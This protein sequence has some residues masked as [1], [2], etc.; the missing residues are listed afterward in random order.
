VEVAYIQ[1]TQNVL[2]GTVFIPITVLV[3][4]FLDVNHISYCIIKVNLIAVDELL[5]D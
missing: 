2:Y 3:T 4:A 1:K 5:K